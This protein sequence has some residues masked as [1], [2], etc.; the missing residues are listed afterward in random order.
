MY[1]KESRNMCIVQKSGTGTKENQTLS[2]VLIEQMQRNC[3]T[4]FCFQQNVKANLLEEHIGSG[5]ICEENG[6]LTFWGEMLTVHFPSQM[7]PEPQSSPAVRLLLKI[8]DL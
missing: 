3:M 8:T 6:K 2:Y 1:I 5:S 7:L 4:Y